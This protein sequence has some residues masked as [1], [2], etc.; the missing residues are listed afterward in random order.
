MKKFQKLNL[1]KSVYPNP[2][3]GDFT[4]DFGATNIT[5]IEIYNSS[6][7]MIFSKETSETKLKLSLDD[8]PNGLYI[9]RAFDLYKNYD[10]RKI[11]V[12]KN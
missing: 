2:T 6:A 7:Q 5:K 3:N 10:E 11:I 1:V 12:Q 9:I 4:I 8:Q